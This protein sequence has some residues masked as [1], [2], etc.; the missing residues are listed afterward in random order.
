MKKI[1]TLDINGKEWFDKVNGNS[2]FS[3]QVVINYGMPNAK[4]IF[5]PFQYGYGDHYK[6]MAVEELNKMKLISE[7]YPNELQDNG[8]II[9]ANMQRNCKKR[10]LAY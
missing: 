2:Y 7:K 3:A 8:V 4:I 5:L 10:E 6:Y 1:K 9:R